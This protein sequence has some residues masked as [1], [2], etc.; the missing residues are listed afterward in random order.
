M[1]ATK[2]I[3]ELR[4]ALLNQLDAQIA[5]TIPVK[6]AKEFSNT[7]GKILQS[8]KLELEYNIHR[9]ETKKIEF[10]TVNEE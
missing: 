9:G 4:N 3:L 1:K 6:T 7:C 5:G 8:A 2:N 10:L